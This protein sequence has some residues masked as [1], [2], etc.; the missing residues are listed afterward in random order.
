MSLSDS[1]NQPWKQW[2]WN[3][4]QNTTCIDGAEQHFKHHSV[5]IAL[6]Y[7]M[8]TVFPFLKTTTLHSWCTLVNLR[9]MRTMGCYPAQKNLNKW[10]LF[11]LELWLNKSTTC[12]K[13]KRMFSVQ[14]FK[15]SYIQ[16][17][18]D[19]HW[20]FELNFFDEQK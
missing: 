13:Y 12:S 15:Q 9:C 19:N 17:T 4:A 11:S 5:V 6:S 2:L 8:G 3:P 7:Y 16:H 10:V 14:F 18:N 20:C 1:G